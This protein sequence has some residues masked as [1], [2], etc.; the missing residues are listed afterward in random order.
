MHWANNKK[1]YGGPGFTARLK[2]G[3]PLGSKSKSHTVH[4]DSISS[5]LDTS[6]AAADASFLG[7]GPGHAAGLAAVGTGERWHG[8]KGVVRVGGIGG[9]TRSKKAP[10]IMTQSA[11]WSYAESVSGLH[12]VPGNSEVSRFSRPI[13]PRSPQAAHPLHTQRDKAAPHA[14]MMSYAGMM[15]LPAALQAAGTDVGKELQHQDPM[16][17]CIE[18]TA[19]T[20]RRPTGSRTGSRTGRGSKDVR[21]KGC[22][23]VRGKGRGGY[24]G[25]WARDALGKRQWIKAALARSTPPMPRP[26]GVKEF[27]A[28]VVEKLTQICGESSSWNTKRNVI[29]LFKESTLWPKWTTAGHSEMTLVNLINRLR[30]RRLAL[31]VSNTRRRAST[32]SLASSTSSASARTWLHAATASSV[33]AAISATGAG[34]LAGSGL[35]RNAEGDSHASYSQALQEPLPVHVHQTGREAAAVPT[36]HH[37]PL[38]PPPTMRTKKVA[39]MSARASLSVLSPLTNT[40]LPQSRPP[41]PPPPPAPPPPPPPPPPPLPSASSHISL[42][43]SAFA[44]TPAASL[45]WLLSSA[46]VPGGQVS[47]GAQGGEAALKRARVTSVDGRREGLKD[48]ET[49]TEGEMVIS[50]CV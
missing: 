7:A 18:T 27:E 37:A 2:R 29:A 45:N 10:K 35:G 30:I 11:A 44:L 34:S 15:S 22:K 43:S 50:A 3:R 8:E 42:L 5:I 21:G 16:E 13:L 26:R 33:S 9:A 31:K 38:F 40:L 46:G 6:S 20:G 28:E 1:R 41:P 4:D 36:P 25:Y 12:H 49:A 32:L 48:G 39:T 14:G 19:I 17:E 24:N 47:L 23:D